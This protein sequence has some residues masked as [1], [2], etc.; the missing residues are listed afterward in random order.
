MKTSRRN[1][2][3]G[4][5]AA[6][7]TGVVLAACA[8]GTGGGESS[9]G[10]EP[11]TLRW[12]TW[13]ND[14]H[15]FNTDAAPKTLALF[16]QKF[17]NV[18]VEVEPQNTGWETKNTADWIAGSGP[19]L[20]GHCCNSGPDWGN[21]GLFLNLDA[22]IKRDS[23]AVPTGDYVEWL[24]KLFNSPQHGQFALPM[25][26]GT[27]HLF[28]NKA[29]FRNKGIP[30]PDDT[31]DWNK[32]REVS[33]RIADVNNQV[34][35]RR[36]IG[37]GAMFKRVHQNGANIVDPK[38]N[39]KAAFATDKALQAFQYERDVVWKDMSVAPSGGPK[40]PPAFTSL[41]G[42]F[43]GHAAIRLGKVAMW[44][45]GSFTIVQYIRFL[46]NEVD[47]D[48]APVPKGP[49]GRFTLATSDGWSIVK[50]TKH[51]DAAWELMK[52]LQSDE[53]TDI[54]TRMAGQQSARKSHQ[55]KWLK[56]FTEANPM[57]QGKTGL[58]W[59][60][61]AIEKNYARPIEFWKKHADSIAIYNAAY[62]KA[63]RDGDAA[64][65]TE[66]RAAADQIN[67]LNK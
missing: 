65:D 38:D 21:Q 48:I 47:W 34:W 29:L 1:V 36:D 26:T 64:V 22:Y 42:Q 37:A 14:Q 13:G 56:A 35:A 2:M 54:G 3:R 28:Y 63:V 11:V 4:A 9:V 33:L 45:A 61:D 40:E 20:S 27:V 66:M 52:H 10:K 43:G 15:P 6:L 39:T 31:W 5:T 8:P 60:A 50:H 53:H 25:Y 30:F 7:G 19:D 32:Y 46:E 59:A 16:N 62:N 57:L 17:P 58:K 49:A 44:E 24:V 12:S 18:K 23:K 51:K 67:A 41:V 55:Q